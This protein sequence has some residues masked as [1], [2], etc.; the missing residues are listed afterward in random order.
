V[1]HRRVNTPWEHKGS[2]MRTLVEETDQPMVLLDGVKVLYDDGWALALPD[3]EEPLTHV[4]AEAQSD[5]EAEQRAEE[6][7]A[8]ITRMVGVR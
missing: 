3:P 8:R 2:V 7:V 1:V 4:W 6:Y 5:A